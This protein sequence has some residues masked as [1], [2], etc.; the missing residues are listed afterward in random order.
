MSSLSLQSGSTINL[1]FTAKKALKERQKVVF[2]EAGKSA[3]YSLPY[4]FQ[5]ID[6]S[7]TTSNGAMNPNAFSFCTAEL[8]GALKYTDKSGTMGS[9]PNF[10]PFPLCRS[11]TQ[12]GASSPG[13]SNTPPNPA[14][15]AEGYLVAEGGSNNEKANWVTSDWTAAITVTGTLASTV[16]SASM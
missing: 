14:Q 8:V 1:A 15:A 12:A 4:L 16:S 5:S 7:P 6:T 10:P 3:S 13:P 11:L 9:H 2:E